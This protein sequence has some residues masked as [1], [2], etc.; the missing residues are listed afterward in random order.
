MMSGS[1]PRISVIIPVRN[2]AGQRLD[3]C[4]RSLRW[5][6]LPDGAHEIVLS[7]FGSDAEH[8]Q[9]VADVAARHGARVVRTPTTELWNRSRAL[10]IGIR[11]ARGDLVLCTDADMIFA[12]DFVRAVIDEIERGEVLVLCRCRDLP[13]DVPEQAW[14]GSDFPGLLARSTFRQTRGTGA[15][16]G[17]KKSFF[18]RV[19]GYDESYVFWGF[20]DNDMVSRAERAGLSVVYIHERTSMLHQWHPTTKNDRPL[21][22]LKNKWRFWLTRRVVTKN[23]TGWG[24]GI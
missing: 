11:A 23:P 7:D 19:R 6:D 24:L 4:L 1:A 17:A 8:A 13:E 12:P 21:L 5:Q 14:D 15:C 20:E 10:N 16:Q 22:K 9:A 18:E 2:R 3:N